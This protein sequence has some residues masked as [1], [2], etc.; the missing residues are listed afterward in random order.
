MKLNY[1]QI[2]SITQGVEEI[3]DKNGV[4]SFYRFN[5]RERDLYSQTEFC[6]KI[7]STAGV[8]MQFRTD[9]TGINIKINTKPATSRTY[10]SMDVF[11]DGLYVGSLKNF[12]NNDTY[13]DYTTKH[14]I[15]GE[16][17]IRLN[18]DTGDKNIRIV[19]PWSVETQ[20]LDLQI[21]NASYIEPLRNKFKLLAYGDSITNGYD[22]LY[23]ANAYITKLANALDM[24][25]INKAIGGEVFVPWLAQTASNEKADYITVAY[26]TNDWSLKERADF[27]E[28]CSKF[29]DALSGNNSDSLIFA[30]T[31]IWRADCMGVRKFGSFNDV[32]N[33]IKDICSKYKNIKVISGWNFVPHDQSCFADLRLHPNDKG[34]NYYYENVKNQIENHI[35][36]QV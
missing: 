21:E 8:Q 29:Y 33:D 15:L 23:S 5:E 6:Q 35:G 7:Y 17:S 16:N 19:F 18:L 34:F 30:L 32:E 11:S 3:V 14:F 28:R 22:A 26:G 2:K 9:G 36:V 1:E 12:D 25:L 10:Y 4:I 31:P 20:L 13:E 24:N 27:K